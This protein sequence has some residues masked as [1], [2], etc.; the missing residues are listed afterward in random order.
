MEYV[1]YA[2]SVV[3]FGIGI[4]FYI[5]HK[6]GAKLYMLMALEIAEKAAKLTKTKI[7]DQ[8]LA[9]L[10]EAI[11]NDGKDVDVDKIVEKMP[12]N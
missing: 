5:K 7:D 12:K 8:L 11:D 9:L 1:L 2:I 6:A 3:C 10:R 4:F